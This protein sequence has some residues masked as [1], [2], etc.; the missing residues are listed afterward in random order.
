MR[1]VEEP[2]RD[3]SISYREGGDVSPGILSLQGTWREESDDYSISALFVLPANTTREARSE[4]GR[5]RVVRRF[6]REHERRVPVGVAG[7][8]ILVVAGINEECDDF[9]EAE[10][11]GQVQAGVG[12]V[13]EVGVVEAR[14]VVL[15]D[16]LDEDEVVQV[17][18]SAEADA[19]VD[20]DGAV[21]LRFL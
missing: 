18:G 4:E 8:A 21:S 16:A 7:D 11:G 5:D 17:D 3:V 19:D 12:F 2:E 6:Y 15:D 9:V 14:G 10:R 13:V 20:P 1:R